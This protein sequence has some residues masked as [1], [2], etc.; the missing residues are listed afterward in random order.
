M[1]VRR[2]YGVTVVALR[3]ADGDVK[4][5]VDSAYRLQADDELVIVGN[6]DDLAQVQSL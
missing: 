5:V 1:D 4:V 6:N 3:R 2:K